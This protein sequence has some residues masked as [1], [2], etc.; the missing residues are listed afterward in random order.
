MQPEKVSLR[1]F[2]GIIPPALTGGGR[3]QDLEISAPSFGSS[4]FDFLHSQGERR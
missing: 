1:A 2:P 3:L 4:I